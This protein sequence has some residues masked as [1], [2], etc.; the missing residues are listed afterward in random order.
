MFDIS[1]LL[2]SACRKN[3]WL[4]TLLGTRSVNVGC[5]NLDDERSGQPA[6]DEKSSSFKSTFTC[7]NVCESIDWLES[8]KLG[9][10]IV[11]DYKWY[12]SKEMTEQKKTV[13]SLGYKNKITC[14]K[15]EMLISSERLD[16]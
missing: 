3:V 5:W 15:Q 12:F 16:M 11:R 13:N 2:R 9:S 10:H 14:V 6:S 1:E 8:K 7:T 4:Q